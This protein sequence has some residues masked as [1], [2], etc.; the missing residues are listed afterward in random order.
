M[1]ARLSIP[2]AML[3]L[4][5]THPAGAQT[6]AP[7]GPPLNAKV[8]EALMGPRT[9]R[10]YLSEDGDHI[11]IVAP[12]GS[13]EVML[14]DGVE[15]P[16]F[17]EIPL[18]FRWSTSRASR[19]SVEF[20]LTGGH[21]AYVGRRGGDFIAVVD[22]KEAATLVTTP[23]MQ[24]GMNAMAPGWGFLFNRDGSRLAYATLAAAGSW[25][26]VADGVRSPSYKALD[27]IQ[28]ALNGKR[29]FYAAQTA[30][31]QWHVVVDGKPG[32]G[33]SG[34]SDLQ[35]TPDGLH[36]VYKAIKAG[37]GTKS[38]TVVN[39]GVETAMYYGVADLDQAP[40]GRIAYVGVTNPGDIQGRGAVANLFVAGMTVPVPRKFN[41]QTYDKVR[42]GY[43]IGYG[44]HMVA[45]SPDGKRVAW[46]QPNTPAPTVS[47]MVNG[48]AMGL[49][50]QTAEELLW[51]PDGAHLTY[52]AV[53]PA[54]TFPVVDG[55]EGTGATW[56]KEFQWS[57]DGKRYI[58]QEAT[59]TGLLVV[60][61]GKPD[62]KVRGVLD[63]S[64]RFSPDG[65]HLAYGAQVGMT[66]DFQP[67]VDGVAK[68]HNLQSFNTTNN[69]KI[70]FPELSWSP[71]GL[72][73]AYVGFTM[74]QIPK[75]GVWVDGTLYPG[76]IAWF[77]FP[78]W[79]PNSK[80]F[81]TVITA[82]AWVAMIDGKLGP[83]YEEFL[84]LSATACRF[85]DDKTFR[86]YGVKAGQVYQ[87]TL[88]MG[89]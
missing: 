53:S 28:S 22:G 46:V 50:Y 15:G 3:L 79:S 19:G 78:S 61:D 34:V 54:G 80:H 29:L 74:D 2:A 20:S 1:H 68:P 27:L 57:P 89:S 48:K 58:Y 71:D 30:D 13:R 76:Q 44:S 56:V 24:S 75:G 11:A 33:Y 25:V 16:L 83:P 39:D 7:V 10:I 9:Q 81:A 88:D 64:E 36:Y 52:Q 12:K 87:V 73:L 60:V 49:T 26:V 40:D 5:T 37:V 59:S 47:V 70:L 38:S 62:P 85:I 14:V 41:V 86:F 31:D 6:Q 66:G 82:R 18:N 63:G 32:P 17:D 43:R 55:T 42:V 67:M 23:V 4:I 84:S 51:S 72:H 21:S 65:K 8:T 45:W 35:V 77:Q 69:P